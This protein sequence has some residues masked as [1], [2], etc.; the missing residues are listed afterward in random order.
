MRSRGSTRIR[1]QEEEEE[2]EEEET[3]HVFRSYEDLA[4]AN[5]HPQCGLGRAEWWNVI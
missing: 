4:P 1:E 2:E 5:L 3:M